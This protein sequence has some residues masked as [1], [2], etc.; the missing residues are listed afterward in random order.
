MESRNTRCPSC[1][2]ILNI[3]NAAEGAMVRCGKC[4]HRFRIPEAAKDLEDTVLGWLED[5]TDETDEEQIQREFSQ[6][7]KPAAPEKKPAP[8]SKGEISLVNLKPPR[9][10]FEFPARRLTEP[11]F[12]CA[13][14]RR[15]LRCGTR[16]HL[17]AHV[18]IYAPQLVDSFSLEAEH[19]AGKLALDASHLQNLPCREILKNLPKVPNVPQPADRPMPY[20]ICDMCGASDMISGQI[21]VNDETGEGSCRLMINNIRR[22]A[23]FMAAAGGEGTPG[24]KE[25][26]E[27]INETDEKPWDQIPQAVQHRIEQWFRPKDNERFLAYVPDRNHA[28]TEDGM[29]GF[30]ISNQR[31]VY[32][33]ARR[34]R[35][36]TADKSLELELAIEGGMGKIHISTP[37]WSVENVKVDREGIRGMRRALTAANFSAH[38]E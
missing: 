25:L 22:A 5:E 16:T 28:R 18:I 31:F 24:Y 20:W 36:V 32:H 30:V 21:E 11:A 3:G 37:T 13:L 8:A 15:C 17:Q 35:E 6:K 19:S 27:Y 12:R 1:G 33:T 7:Q 29:A 23:E 14:P 26:I 4:K 2:T 9:A 10:T 38:W 34:H